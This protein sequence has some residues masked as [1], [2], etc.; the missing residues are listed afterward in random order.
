MR[1]TD[2]I[3]GLTFKKKHNR[4]P[5]QEMGRSR[6]RRREYARG[7]SAAAV[8]NKT[9]LRGS[10]SKK[11]WSAV[12][13]QTE[14]TRTGAKRAQRRREIGARRARVGPGWVTL[15]SEPVSVTRCCAL[16]RER[17]LG[18]WEGKV[19]VGPGGREKYGGPRALGHGPGAFRRSARPV[20]S[21]I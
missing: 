2:V 21:S 18:K 8:V 12:K 5:M 3:E 11:Q 10:R 20:S 14:H 13:G 4:A 9:E 19:C 17:E 1:N 15:C 16:N 7:R 6:H